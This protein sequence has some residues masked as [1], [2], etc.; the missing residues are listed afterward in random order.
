MW[1][2]LSDDT[3]RRYAWIQGGPWLISLSSTPTTESP[4]YG[5]LPTATVVAF[6][7]HTSGRALAAVQGTGIYAASL[8]E[9]GSPSSYPNTPPPGAPQPWAAAVSGLTRRDVSCMFVDRGG[10]CYAGGVG[11]GLFRS[12]DA[13]T[14]WDDISR[15]PTFVTTVS[16]KD[17]NGNPATAYTSTGFGLPQATVIAVVGF[18]LVL[19]TT[20]QLS[21]TPASPTM[22]DKEVTFGA[23]VTGKGGGVPTGSITITDDF[24]GGSRVLLPATPVDAAGS[25]QVAPALLSVDTHTITATFT[26][27]GSWQNSEVSLAYVVTPVPTTTQLTSSTNPALMLLPVTF[28]AAVAGSDGGVPTGS[29]TFTDTF[30]GTTSILASNVA[31]DTTGHAATSWSTLSFGAHT[32]TAT[33]TG[34][35]GFTNSESSLQQVVYPFPLDTATSPSQASTATT[36]PG[37]TA[38]TAT[39]TASPT[40]APAAPPTATEAAPAA[41]AAASKTAAPAGATGAS[42]TAAP[43]AAT[44]LSTTPPPT[45]FAAA[46]KTAAPAAIKTAGTTVA[47]A[48]TTAA[49]GLEGSSAAV[50]GAVEKALAAE[51]IQVP[52][53]L[54]TS[55]NAAVSALVG[56]VAATKPGMTKGVTSAVGS[57]LSTAG[58]DVPAELRRSSATRSARS[59]RARARASRA[60]WRAWSRRGSA[61]RGWWLRR[62]SPAWS[63]PG[64]RRSRAMSRRRRLPSAASWPTASRERSPGPSL[65]SGSTCRRA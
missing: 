59:R 23:T 44:T 10:I 3:K 36:S 4:V 46:G 54:S 60:T 62:R 39:T 25:V 38:A 6:V 65:R 41:T 13:G 57:A 63:R 20:M 40:A 1:S 55:V 58:C 26:G 48:A 7:V 31:V 51:G 35:G 18:T 17:A 28:T 30:N 45:A 29:V 47:P 33:F 52:T 56:H 43:A 32:I 22:A 9:L 2:S 61:L 34:T 49:S 50:L 21:V 14:T 64:S 12:V 27:T 19:P 15:G 53:S 8:A 37:G 5:G 42:K 24:P 16:G 11:G